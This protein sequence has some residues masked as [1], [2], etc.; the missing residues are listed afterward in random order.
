HGMGDD[1]LRYD[2]VAR[3]F[4]RAG[5]HVY[6]NDHRGHGRTARNSGALGDFGRGGWDA[7]VE[8]MAALMRLARGREAGLSVVLLGHSMGSFA[9]QQYLLDHSDLIAG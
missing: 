2:H 7:L 4:N 5:F 8:D 9:A 6:S 1:S 3:F